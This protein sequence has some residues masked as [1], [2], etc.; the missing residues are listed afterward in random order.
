ME[1]WGLLAGSLDQPSHRQ[2]G[3]G[4]GHCLAPGGGSASSAKVGCRA[5]DSVCRI[6]RK[7]GTKYA[8]I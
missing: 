1:A 4:G 6:V 7:I 5:H 3:H 8:G 2:F